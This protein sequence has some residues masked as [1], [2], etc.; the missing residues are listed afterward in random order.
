M[1]NEGDFS[2]SGMVVGASVGGLIS[3]TRKCL[4]YARGQ[5]RV[6]GLF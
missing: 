2:D 6:A 3:H 5:R 4:V 1:G